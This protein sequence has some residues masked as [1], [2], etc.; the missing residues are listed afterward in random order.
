MTK[1][2][3]RKF[4]QISRP[5]LKASCLA[6][7]LAA[8]LAACKT[9]NTYTAE[10]RPVSRA[11]VIDGKTDDW[12]GDLYVVPGE[13]LSIGFLN[14][15]DNLYVCLL[16]TDPYTRFQIM[17][18]GLTVWFDPKGGKDKVFGIKFPLGP[19][20]GQQPKMTLS[21]TGEPVIDESAGTP[22]NEFEIIRSEK[23]PVQRM[24]FAQAKG[25][26][27]KVASSTGLIV[28]EMKIPLVSNGQDPVAVGVLPGKTVGIGF[29]TGKFD[30]SKMP[31][32]DRGGMPGGGGMGGR[33][34]GGGGRG[35]MDGTAM[36]G[37]IPES[38]KVWALVQLSSGMSRRPADVVSIAKKP[39]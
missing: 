10:S 3:Q 4:F 24:E 31:R 35:A 12:Q 1:K 30:A 13:R 18:Q 5:V 32:S 34:Q 25:L 22:M 28:Y 9:F 20:A 15:R 16:T 33:S 39:E 29:E 14:D 19:P 37:G 21:A 27:I 7:A 2:Q 6:L 26:E 23:E 38:L 36:R 11:I 8:G 17:G